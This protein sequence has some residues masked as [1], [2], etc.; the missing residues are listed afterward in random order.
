MYYFVVSL[1]LKRNKTSVKAF[2][3]YKRE[4]RL[5]EHSTF[6]FMY[7]LYHVHRSIFFSFFAV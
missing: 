5:L 7:D 1:G 2:F 3:Y 4:S 6:M